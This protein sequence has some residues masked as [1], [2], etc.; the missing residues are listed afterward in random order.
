MIGKLQRHFRMIIAL[1]DSVYCRIQ[2]LERYF[3]FLLNLIFFFCRILTGK[4]GDS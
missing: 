2:L 4:F 1:N 3:Y